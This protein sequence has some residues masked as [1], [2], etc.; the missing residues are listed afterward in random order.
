MFISIS[1]V[2]PGLISVQ[3]I[4]QKSWKKNCTFFSA[5]A[6]LSMKNEVFAV[7]EKFIRYMYNESMVNKVFLYHDPAVVHK[8]AYCYRNKS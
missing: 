7:L 6:N 2:N 5:Q 3:Q 8:M 4:L 1:Y